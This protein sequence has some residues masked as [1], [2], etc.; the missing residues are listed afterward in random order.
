[1]NVMTNGFG[2]MSDYVAQVPVE[3]RWAIA[4]Y[5]RALQLSQRAAVSDVPADRRPE[6]DQAPPTAPQVGAPAAKPA[7]ETP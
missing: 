3:D 6:L 5:V 2:A 4:A 1:V 7:S